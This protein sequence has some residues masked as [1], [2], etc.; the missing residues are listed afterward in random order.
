MKRKIT[1]AQEAWCHTLLT[2]LSIE[3]RHGKF[4]QFIKRSTKR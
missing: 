4:R 3:K 1:A 2:F